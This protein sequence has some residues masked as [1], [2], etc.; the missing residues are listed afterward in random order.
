MVQQFFEKIRRFLKT[1]HGQWL[2]LM[3]IRL[4]RRI[5]TFKF[6]WNVIALSNLILFLWHGCHLGSHLEKH[7]TLLAFTSCSYHIVWHMTRLQKGTL[8]ND[9]WHIKGINLITYKSS[10]LHFATTIFLH[11]WITLMLSKLYYIYDTA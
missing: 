1:S 2:S 11:D 10:I 6:P 8:Y 4:Q 9:T 3:E 5:A 7:F